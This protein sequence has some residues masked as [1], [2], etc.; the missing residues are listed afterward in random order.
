MILCVG[1][2][3]TTP[4]L[5]INSFLALISLISSGIIRAAINQYYNS[6]KEKMQMNKMFIVTLLGISGVI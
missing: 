2:I 4:Y 6:L 5:F 3:P 1:A